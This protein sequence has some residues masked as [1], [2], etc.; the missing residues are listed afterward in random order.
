M[1]AVAGEVDSGELRIGGFDAFGIF[2]FVE[3][4]AHG[5]SGFGGGCC[6]QLYDGFEAAQRFT[7]PVQRDK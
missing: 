1:E 2:V 7:A 6:D 4:G 3:F 5:E